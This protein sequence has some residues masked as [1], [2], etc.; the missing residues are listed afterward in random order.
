MFVDWLLQAI[1]IRNLW[2]G[3]I[4]PSISTQE[5]EG[6][7]QKFGKIEG[8]AFSHD[9]TSAY[10]NFEKLE[11]AIFYHRAFNGMDFGGKELCV[12]SWR[13]R[14]GVVCIYYC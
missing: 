8:V 2:V 9:Q 5:V 1:A 4:S 13:S 14:E 10:I 11:V 7:F 3:R 12:D 6:E